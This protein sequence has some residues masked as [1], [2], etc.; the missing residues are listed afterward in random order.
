VR[1]ARGIKS[2]PKQRGGPK[3]KRPLTVD[4]LLQFFSALLQRRFSVHQTIFREAVVHEDQFLGVGHMVDQNQHRCPG[5][6]IE[7]FLGAVDNDPIPMLVFHN[8]NVVVD[9]PNGSLLG[10]GVADSLIPP[11][12]LFGSILDFPVD[13]LLEDEVVLQWPKPKDFGLDEAACL[14][15]F[16]DIEDVGFRE[17]GT[18]EFV[19]FCVAREG[20]SRQQPKKFEVG[21]FNHFPPRCLGQMVGFV[22]D[23]VGVPDAQIR[24]VPNTSVT[25]KLDVEIRADIFLG[26]LSL[27]HLLPCMC[28]P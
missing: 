23:D 2:L 19:S 16:V 18:K 1:H 11:D 26:C 24:R 27:R 13:F 7:H 17:Q 22:A 10:R 12:H 20:R 4:E 25:R 8:P 14:S 28:Q 15:D 5:V 3:E 21:L 6:L 9:Q